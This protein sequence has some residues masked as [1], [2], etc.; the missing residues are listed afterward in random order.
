MAKSVEVLDARSNAPENLEYAAQAIG[1]SSNRLAIFRE[2]YRHTAAWKSA[3]AIAAKIGVPRMN[4]I[5]DI[6]PL[7]NKG[8]VEQ[9]R[10]SG[11][12]YYGVVRFYKAHR[13]EIIELAKNPKKLSELA[14][15]RRPKLGVTVRNEV[16]YQAVRIPTKSFEV[17]SV[18]IDDIE[19]F[20]AVKMIPMNGNLIGMSETTFKNGIQ[21]IL[22]AVGD[23]KDW[24][25]E[26]SDLYTANVILAGKR[27]ASAF[28]FKGPGQSG[29]LTIAR[30]G[31]NG[32]QAVR[33]LRE[34]AS[35]FV[36]QHWREIDSEV[37]DLIRSLAIAR[38]ATTGEPIFYC[39]INGQDSDRLVRAYPDA[40]K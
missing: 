8:I 17:R 6:R 26:K 11:D 18:T 4:I 39:I 38:S 16:A 36:V 21:R 22:V 27:R 14:T 24:G 1:R 29:K 13:D 34:P 25:G 7:V 23:F 40:F 10:R 33:L 9:D 31:K 3:T 30:M 15:K 37:I 2:V 32:D 28:A 19:S 35:V 20:A 5:K 12:E